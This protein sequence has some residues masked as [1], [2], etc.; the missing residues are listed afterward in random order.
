MN[1]INI[2]SIVIIILL[3]IGCTSWIGYQ[4]DSQIPT[5]VAPPKKL[6]QNDTS[7]TITTSNKKTPSSTITKN[8]SVE[9][10][11]RIEED[12]ENGIVDQIKVNNKDM[13]SYYIYPTQPQ[14][15]NTNPIPDRNV[16]TPN[17]QINW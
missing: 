15:Y 3:I 1:K 12:R 2:C 10:Q 7:R 17:W 6:E 4:S 5:I 13:P 16:S 11:E 8:K 9:S 14:N